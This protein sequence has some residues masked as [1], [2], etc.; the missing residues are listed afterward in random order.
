MKYF[1]TSPEIVR[2]GQAE[3]HFSRLPAILSDN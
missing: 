2:I 1:R 3:G